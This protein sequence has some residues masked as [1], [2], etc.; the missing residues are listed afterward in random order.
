MKMTMRTETDMV[1]DRVRVTDMG[2][3]RVIM[4]SYYDVS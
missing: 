2:T 1:T 3:D 4:I